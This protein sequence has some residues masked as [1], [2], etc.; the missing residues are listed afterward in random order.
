M[1]LMKRFILL[2]DHFLCWVAMMLSSLA[3]EQV[4]RLLRSPQEENG[5]SALVI[6]FQDHLGGVGTL[7]LISSYYHG[8]R[9]G[10]TSEIDEHVKELGG[11]KSEK[12]GGIL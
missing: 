4:V 2:R 12:A 6:E 10:F 9:K 1:R 3:E 8:Y 5:A 7:G 11:P